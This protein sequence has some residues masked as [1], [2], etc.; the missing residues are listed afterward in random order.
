M[1]FGVSCNG[2][3]T[4]YKC[5]VL[6]ADLHLYHPYCNALLLLSL[7]PVWIS[8]YVFTHIYMYYIS[9]VSVLLVHTDMCYISM[10][11]VISR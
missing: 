5:M 10:V 7:Y 8:T 4:S 11:R 3:L 1:C 9:I 2:T 6:G